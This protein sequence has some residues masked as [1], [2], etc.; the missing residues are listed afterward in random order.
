[1]SHLRAAGFAAMREEECHA[2]LDELC[3]PHLE[4][5]S[6]LKAQVALGFEN[7]ETL[8][9]K[10]IEDPGWMHDP[11]FKHLYLVRTLGGSASSA[12]YSVNYGLLLAAAD[13]LPAAVDIINDAMCVSCAR[14]SRSSRRTS[15]RRSPCMSMAST[16][17]LRLS[18]ARGC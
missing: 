10:G 6:L 9:S 14:H 12:E 11:L 4:P 2:M 15:I 8:R 13:S 7:P 3:N 18:C 1:M 5:S 16:R 17:S